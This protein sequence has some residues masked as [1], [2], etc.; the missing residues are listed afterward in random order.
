[1]VSRTTEFSQLPHPFNAA[2]NVKQQQYKKKHTKDKL[3]HTDTN[4]INSSIG[5]SLIAQTVL[6]Y[7]FKMRLLLWDV[8]ESVL[9]LIDLYRLSAPLLQRKRSKLV[10]VVWVFV[11]W[12]WLASSVTACCYTCSFNIAQCSVCAGRL[13]VLCEASGLGKQ[14]PAGLPLGPPAANLVSQGVLCV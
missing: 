2:I 6:C 5:L 13:G 4:I 14:K 12:Q 10:S 1:M 9:D 3:T 11:P 8:S 7:G